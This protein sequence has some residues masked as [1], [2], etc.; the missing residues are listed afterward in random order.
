MNKSFKKGKK[1][2]KP[3]TK[4]YETN[5]TRVCYVAPPIAGFLHTPLC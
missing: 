5:L 1:E 3:P 4:I 2:K